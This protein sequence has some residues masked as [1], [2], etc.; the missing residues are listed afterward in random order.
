MTAPVKKTT[1]KKK[2]GRRPKV[3]T[4]KVDLNKETVV[5]EADKET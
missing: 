1:E 4:Q 5:I 3:E 2:R